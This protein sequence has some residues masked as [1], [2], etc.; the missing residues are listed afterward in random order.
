MPKSYLFSLFLVLYALLNELTGYACLTR[1]CLCTGLPRLEDPPVVSDI[2]C[3]SMLIT[4][5]RWRETLD[6]GEEEGMI[7]QYEYEISLQILHYC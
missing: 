6:I 5:P 2:T 7:A 1:I 3:D 4:W